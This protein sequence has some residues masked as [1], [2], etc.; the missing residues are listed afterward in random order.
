MV[1]NHMMG[2]IRVE[3]HHHLQHK[4]QQSLHLPNIL[5]QQIQKLDDDF[6]CKAMCHTCHSLTCLMWNGVKH[7]VKMISTVVSSWTALLLLSLKK[8]TVFRAAEI[9]ILCSLFSSVSGTVFTPALLHQAAIS[10]GPH[11]PH[12]EHHDDNER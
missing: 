11:N 9:S 10:K 8:T 5:K 3:V 7:T 12:G 2:H 4:M 1:D 6:M